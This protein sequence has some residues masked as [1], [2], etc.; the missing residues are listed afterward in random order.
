VF[1]LL[2]NTELMHEAS[3]SNYTHFLLLKFGIN[4]KFS[5]ISA[6]PLSFAIGY[7]KS[8]KLKINISAADKQTGRQAANGLVS[9]HFI[10]SVLLFSGV[11]V[12]R[13]SFR[14]CF[15]TEYENVV[16]FRE[17]LRTELKNSYFLERLCPCFSGLY[18]Q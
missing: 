8:L 9:C 4:I 10:I 6:S 13:L 11:F 16:W 18:V 12:G 5:Q 15:C 14:E 3:S 1:Q 7:K 2:L 17:C